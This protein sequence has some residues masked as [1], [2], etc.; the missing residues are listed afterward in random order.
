MATCYRHPSRETGVSCSSCGRP[1]CPDC[2]TTTPVGMRCPECSQAA[3]QSCACATPPPSRGHLR[4]DRDQRGR[5]PGRGQ[6]HAVR[7]S[8]RH[9][10]IDKARCS[11]ASRGFPARASPTGSG[12]GSSQAAS[13]TRTSCTSAS[14]CTF[15]ISSGRCSSRRSATEVRARLFRLAARGLAR[16]ADR[17]TARAHRGRLRSR[18][19]AAGRRRR[20]DAR[21]SDSHHAERR[22]RAHPHQPGHQLHAPG[23][24]LGRA[25]RWSDRRHARG[26]RSPA[27][28]PLP[29]AGR[30]RGGLRAA[31]G[32]LLRGSI[33][34]AHSS[35]PESETVPPPG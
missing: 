24:L 30:G 8:P 28:R 1:I 18:V 22:R 32:G 35:L 20:R 33:A 7:V 29:L 25:H 9:A 23:H 13:C 17:L 16:R 26:H 4:A 12:G 15:S 6:H 21:P 10:S 31:R 3:D 19:R 5:L 34:V 27:R 11:A 2:M 14:T